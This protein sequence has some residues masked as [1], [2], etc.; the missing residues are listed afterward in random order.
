[1]GHPNDRPIGLR[2]LVVPLRSAKIP[3]DELKEVVFLGNPAF[4][5]REWAE[6][7]NLPKLTMVKGDPLNRADLRAVSIRYCSMW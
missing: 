3:Y 5:E 4:L 6:L 7:Y 2:E 1:M